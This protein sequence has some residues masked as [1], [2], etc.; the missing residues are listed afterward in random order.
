[1]IP[2][3]RSP[4]PAG[5]LSARRASQR[6]DTRTRQR[7]EADIAKA[8]DSRIDRALGGHRKGSRLLSAAILAVGILVVVAA[9]LFRQSQETA[10]AARSVRVGDDSA[11]VLTALGAPAARCGVGRL[12]HLAAAMPPGTPRPTTEETL[13][14]L[15]QGT[16]SRWVWGRG[17]GCTPRDGQTEI[18]F[19]RDGRVFWAVAELGGDPATLP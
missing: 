16:V 6:C 8:Y 5:S 17:A 13:A 14:T 7:R 10:R 12:A 15:R 19:T 18:G 2:D 1:L 3:P 9:I 4:I 11:S